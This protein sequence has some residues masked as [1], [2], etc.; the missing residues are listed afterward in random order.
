MVADL[1]RQLEQNGLVI[2]PGLL[3]NEQLVGV[4]RA[5]G[6][7]LRRQRWNDVDGYE[8][9]EPYRHMVQ[10]IL[11]LH[12]GFVDLA[13]HPTVKA[14]LNAYLGDYWALVEAKGWLSLPT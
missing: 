14:V 13:L 5:F 7:R 3:S 1:V 2:L 10:D 9:T 12:Q 8:K 4:Q 11:T 6:S